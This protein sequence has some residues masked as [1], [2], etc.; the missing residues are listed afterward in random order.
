LSLNSRLCVLQLDQ[1]PFA[2][3][4]PLGGTKEENNCAFDPFSEVLFTAK[5]IASRKGEGL[6]P[7]VQPNGAKQFEG[8]NPNRIVPQGAFDCS[9]ASQMNQRPR[10][11]GRERKAVE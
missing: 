3:P 4:L 11:A 9:A 6:L 10:P 1:L 8:G 7:D 5:L 2:V